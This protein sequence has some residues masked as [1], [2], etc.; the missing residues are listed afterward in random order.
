MDKHEETLSFED[1]LRGM[2]PS[3][4]KALGINQLAY[5]KAD[6]DNGFELRAADGQILAKFKT[7]EHAVTATED[8]DLKAVTVH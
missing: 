8:Q 1:F 6:N 2:T 7:F 3:A 4:F 5:I